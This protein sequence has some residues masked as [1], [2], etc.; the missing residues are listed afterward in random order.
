MREHLH[1]VDGTSR[2][3]LT[4]RSFP[5]NQILVLSPEGG[6]AAGQDKEIREEECS[7]LYYFQDLLQ[8]YHILS[9]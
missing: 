8:S 6:E 5:E 3:K 2:E 7:R 1:P 9:G 4:R